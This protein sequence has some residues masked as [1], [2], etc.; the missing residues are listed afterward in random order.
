MLLVVP[1]LGYAAG[2]PTAGDS[3]P[4]VL[5]SP[6]A[7]KT[8]ETSGAGNVTTDEGEGIL[9]WVVTQ[10]STGP[11]IVEVQAGLNHLGAAADDKGWQD[12]VATGAQNVTSIGLT[13]STVYY[14]HY[15]QD[16]LTINNSLV[17]TSGSF[18]TDAVTIG[19]VY[20]HRKRRRRD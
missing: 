5:T 9:Y 12:V 14:I 3:T 6:T 2:A 13:P 7:V 20:V 11:T 1:N 16:D 17:V 4:P 15:Q 8:G 10:S 19:N 18:T